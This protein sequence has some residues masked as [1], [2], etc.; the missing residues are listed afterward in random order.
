MKRLI[1]KLIPDSIHSLYRY[2]FHHGVL[3]NIIHPK[4]FNEKIA[5]RMRRPKQFYALLADKLAVREY[6]K[7]RI[8]TDYLIPL[9]WQGD[10]LT[11]NDWNH[12]PESFVIKANHAS[13]T[14][15]IVTSKAE[16]AFS[17]VLS[18][19][20][21]WL[22]MDFSRI[23]FEKHYKYIKPSLMVEQ[24]L[25][26]DDGKIPYDYK[27]HCF[28]SKQGSKFFIQVDYD[29]FEDNGDA[30]T[31]DFFDEDWNFIPFTLDHPN[32][33]IPAEKPNK[34]DELLSL[35]KKLSEGLAYVRID[36]YIVNNKPLFGEITLTHGCAGE[37]FN[38]EKYNDIWGELWN[39]D[40]EEKYN[41]NKS[42]EQAS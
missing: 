29:R 21:S 10:K 17:D 36:W 30:H 8:G 37:T 28:N 6:I 3:P 19:T 27:V 15:L 2:Y 11:I 5:L 12:F 23:N 22:E 38:P 41:E 32:S 13:G 26:S 31:R 42:S 33:T 1:K 20:N 35:S 24:L 18:L 16:H 7:N 4:K 39:D 9:L 34:L 25:V 40:Y 14:N